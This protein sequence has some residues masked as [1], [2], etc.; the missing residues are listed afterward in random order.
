[1]TDEQF[2][3]EYKPIH[4]PA[5]YNDATTEQDKVMY[6]LAQIGEGTAL[7]VNNELKKKSANIDS[8]IILKQLFDTGHIKGSVINGDMHYN[9]SKITHANDGETDPGLLAPGLD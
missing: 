3:E 5:H 4:I 6:A 1:M 7:D 8:A 2:R 9:L